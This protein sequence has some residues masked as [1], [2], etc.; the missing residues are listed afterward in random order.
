MNGMGY[1]NIQGTKPNS[2]SMLLTDSPVGLL[3]WIYDCLYTWSDHANHEWTADEVITWVCL[4]YFSKGGVAATV[5][6]YYEE[7]SRKPLD[8]FKESAAYTKVPMGVAHFPQEMGSLPRAWLKGMAP[9]VHCSEWE[10]GGH[11]AAWER[12]EDLVADLRAMFGKGGGAE[13]V[14]NGKSGYDS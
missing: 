8:R 14:I 13:G 9:V 3:T 6:I 4:Y 1:Y 12:P 2:I 5:R 11:F 7:T 10:K